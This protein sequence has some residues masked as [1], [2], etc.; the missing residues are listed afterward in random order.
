MYKC[1]PFV[2]LLYPSGGFWWRSRRRHFRHRCSFVRSMFHSVQSNVINSFYLNA[3]IY[4]HII[5][6]RWWLYTRTFLT[7]RPWSNIY[8]L[9]TL[10]SSNLIDLYSSMFPLYPFESANQWQWSLLLLTG[11]L[12]LW[13]WCPF[14]I[15]L[16][17]S[18]III[19]KYSK[20]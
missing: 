20:H 9:H 5:Y 7:S 17:S 2:C 15:I 8:T 1:T 18:N 10:T 13:V 4:I 11:S 6:M 16:I 19:V 3:H 12:P 14:I